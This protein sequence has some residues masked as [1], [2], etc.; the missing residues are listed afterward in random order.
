MVAYSSVVE[1]RFL[2]SNRWTSL[3]YVP[4]CDCQLI[5]DHL[6]YMGKP[7]AVSQLNRPTQPFILSG[8]IKE[9]SE[10]QSDGCYYY[11]KGRSFSLLHHFQHQTKTQANHVNPFPT[12][13]TFGFLPNQC[14]YTSRILYGSRYTV[15]YRYWPT[16]VET[17]ILHS[18]I[19]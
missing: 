19:R 2:I 17:P 12:I 8:S 9:H 7:S 3:G 16:Y 18:V 4:H 1:R 10:L 5:G 6:Q 13:S 14:K 15:I 11:C